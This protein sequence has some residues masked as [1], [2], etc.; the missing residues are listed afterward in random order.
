M[1][2]PNSTYLVVS[3]AVLFALACLN[4][5]AGA[6]G[7]DEGVIP[8]FNGYS[9]CVVADLNGDGHVDIAVSYSKIGGPPPHA[10]VVAIYLQD[11][12]KPGTFPSSLQYAVGNDPV[13]LA[14][15]D[16][17]GDGKIDLVSSNT[18]MNA[19]GSGS[20]SVSV[21]LQD[22]AN[23]GHF[24][25]AVNYAT[26]FSPV[27]V[28]IGD[29]NGDGKPDLAVA[30]MS[31]VSILL[32]DASAPGQF[33]PF[34][35]LPTSSGW[36]SGV[37]IADLNGDGKPDMV[38]TA[39]DVSVYLQDPNTPG[40]FLAA[41]HYGAGA[42]PYG[43]AIQDLNAD[44][45]P[46]LAIA[47]LGSP[48]GSIPASMSVLL[49][50]PVMPGSF[51]TATNYATGVRS[52]T[53]AAADLNDDGKQDLAVGNQGSF[54]GGSVSVFLQ[55]PAYSGG[56]L[57]ATNY[58]DTGVVSWVA[59]AD[60]DGDNRKDLVIVASGVEIRLQD[61]AHPGTFLQPVSIVTD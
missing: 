38:V 54:N 52:W 18:I 1:E 10:G 47:N 46:D 37:A 34:N 16:L 12:A 14:G 45:H 25:S 24:L 32:Q 3:V 19:D 15:A 4:S 36:S 17:N 9:S 44:G 35:T 56:F 41:V 42:Q 8:P 28:A 48:D 30:D 20:S 33:L 11:P 60:I 29:L 49:Q 50:D 53:I 43:M 55:N 26:G 59:A 5:C 23:P 40:K 51:L 22:S 57:P 21:L 31:G 2:R 13:A 27:G 39:A 58:S 7:K 61:P 6:K